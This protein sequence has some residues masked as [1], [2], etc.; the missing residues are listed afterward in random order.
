MSIIVY[1]INAFNSLYDGCDRTFQTLEDALTFAESL[2]NTYETISLRKEIVGPSH[3]SYSVILDYEMER[4]NFKKIAKKS[5]PS[6]RFSVIDDLN[7]DLEDKLIKLGHDKFCETIVAEL[8]RAFKDENV[9]IGS[10]WELGF[11]D[12]YTKALSV[13]RLAYLEHNLRKLPKDKLLHYLP[14]AI[15]YGELSDTI[16]DALEEAKK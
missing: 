1:T 11:T 10:L 14:T 13:F 6:K 4:E 15:G 8:R 9:E 16:Y 5:P 3:E 7:D 12:D 2:R